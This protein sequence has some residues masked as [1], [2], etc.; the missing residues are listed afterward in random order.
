MCVG[1]GRRTRCGVEIEAAWAFYKRVLSC[2]VL[3][4]YSS[5]QDQVS[6]DWLAEK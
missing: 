2:Y 1:V 4:C 3:S 5:D 6:S